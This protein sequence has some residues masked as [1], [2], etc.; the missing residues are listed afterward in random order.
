ML[1]R[2]RGYDEL[3]EADL[4]TWLEHTTQRF[5]AAVAADVLIYFGAIEALLAGLAGVLDPGGR[6][7][8][9]TIETAA[10][11]SYALEPT[12][13]FSH[14]PSYVAAARRRA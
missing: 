11:G 13:R 1:A 14:D 8:L 6:L 7:V 2:A 12:G 4:V 10:H 5:G 9:S 3:V